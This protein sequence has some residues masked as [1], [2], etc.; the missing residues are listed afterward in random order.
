MLDQFE[1]TAPDVVTLS[2]Q[3]KTE[4]AAWNSKWEPIVSRTGEASTSAPAAGSGSSVPGRVLCD[5]VFEVGEEPIDHCKVFTFPEDQIIPMEALT[6]LL[7]FQ[8]LF[9]FFRCCAHT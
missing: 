8:I 9:W 2:S 1:S 7:G 6:E 5:P 4:I 3:I